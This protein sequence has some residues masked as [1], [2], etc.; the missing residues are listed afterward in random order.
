MANGQKHRIKFNKSPSSDRYCAIW[1][2]SAMWLRYRYTLANYTHIKIVYP[3]PINFTFGEN[4]FDEIDFRTWMRI[5]KMRA[6]NFYALIPGLGPKYGLFR[7]LVT[8][9][10]VAEP[11]RSWTLASKKVREKQVLCWDVC[12]QVHDNRLNV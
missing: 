8:S 5:R 10:F 2:I 1:I 6:A 7:S 11:K 9:V 12:L 4:F 3:N